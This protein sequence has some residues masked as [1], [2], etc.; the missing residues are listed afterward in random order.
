MGYDQMHYPNPTPQFNNPWTSGQSQG[1]YPAPTSSMSYDYKPA[2]QKPTSIALPYSNVPATSAPTSY[3]AYSQ[4]DL[5]NSAPH[6]G[7]DS[8]YSSATSH[9]ATYAPSTS[10]YSS[11]PSYAQSLAA[12]QQDQQGRRPSATSSVGSSF[13]PSH[14]SFGDAIE[15]SRGMVAMAHNDVTPRNIYGRGDRN[16]IDSYGF[17]GAH[18]THSSIS[19]AS[20]YAPHYGYAGSVD[21]SATDY[22]SASESID[23]LSHSRTLPRPSALMPG[24][25]PLSAATGVAGHMPPAPASMMGSFN[26]KVSSSAQKKHKC[27]VCDKRFT[28]PSSLQTHMYSHTGEKPFQCEVPGCGR[29]FS[30]VSNLRRHKKVH[31][32]DGSIA[33]KDGEGS[34]HEE[35]EDNEHEGEGNS[36][37]GSWTNGR[38]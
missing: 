16:G 32:H 23:G 7:Y 13:P 8:G 14:S 24:G 31:K 6:T 25:L 17:P 36:P 29:N 5:M 33:S 1:G 2:V 38:D 26:S 34:V 18:S 37:D 9:P 4:P 19:S 28:R 12:Q 22:S 10:S 35:D 11:M 27:K 15:A 21:G 3:P 20:G 30:V